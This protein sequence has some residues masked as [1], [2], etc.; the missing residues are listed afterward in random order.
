MVLNFNPEDLFDRCF[1]TLDARITKLN[2]FPGIS[3]DNMVMLFRSVR[4]FKLCQVL[5]LQIG[6]SWVCVLNSTLLVFL[7]F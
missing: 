4:F 7:K 3:N 6:S 5:A 1:D 2:D